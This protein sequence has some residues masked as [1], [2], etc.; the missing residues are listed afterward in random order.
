MHIVHQNDATYWYAVPE[1]PIIKIHQKP[2]FDKAAI[3]FGFT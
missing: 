1:R 2:N 3:K